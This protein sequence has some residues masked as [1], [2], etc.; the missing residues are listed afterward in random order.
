MA[1][2]PQAQNACASRRRKMSS[3]QTDSSVSAELGHLIKSFFEAVSFQEGDKPHYHLIHELFVAQG[4]L[5][6]N[7][8]EVPEI[9]SLSDF[10]ASRQASVSAGDLTR[11]FEAELSEATQVFGNVAQRFSTYEKSGMLKGAA[12]AA[13]GVVLTQ[14]IRTPHGW[15]MGSMAWDDERPGLVIPEA[16][17]TARMRQGS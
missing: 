5:I 7:S 3:P 10:I 2:A 13:K 6:K 15:R 4:L 9:S 11:F 16:T 12:F 17:E 14:F 1:T 8:G